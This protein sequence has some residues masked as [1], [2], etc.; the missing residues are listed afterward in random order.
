MANAFKQFLLRWLV[1]FFGLWTAATLLD[2]IHYQDHLAVLIWAS[3]IFSLVNAFIRPLI[4]ILSLP[5]IIL[6]LGLFTFIINAFMLYLVTLFYDKF[7]I[8]SFWSAILAVFII[9][10]VNF[11]LNDLLEPKTVK[12]S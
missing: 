1:N 12:P 5:A 8:A 9:W 11:L 2:G 4:V 10:V 7:Q 3:L 6:S